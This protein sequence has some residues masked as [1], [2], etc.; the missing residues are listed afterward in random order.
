MALCEGSIGPLLGTLGGNARQT[1]GRTQ[2]QRTQDAHARYQ[3]AVL[4]GRVFTGAN[5]Q[6]TPVTTQAGVSATTPALTLFNPPGSNTHLVLWNAGFVFHAAP[7]AACGLMLAY[8]VASLAGVP[9]GPVTTT[10]ATVVNN[11]IGSSI[12]A[13]PVGQCYR[14]ATLSAA[15]VAFV[16]LGGTT[17]A[18][19]IGGVP[20]LYDLGGAWAIPPGIAVSVQ[21]DS[22]ASLLASLSWEEVP[23]PYYQL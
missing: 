8:N 15:P 21:T 4:N 11:L 3:D 7:A 22:A 5:P 14:V 17:G 23:A 18:A 9:T 13:G 12:T 2:A 19:A 16:Y 10:L 20:L 1:F 6:G